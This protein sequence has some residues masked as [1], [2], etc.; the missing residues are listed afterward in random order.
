[1]QRNP[2]TT[3]AAIMALAIILT[4]S[5]GVI[6]IFR[7]RSLSDT[8]SVTGSAEQTVMSDVAKWSLQLTQSA[9]LYNL[10]TANTAISADLGTLRAFLSERGIEPDWITIQPVS[11]NTNYDYNKGGTPSGYMLMQTVVV[12]GNDIEK[13]KS[14]AENVN[15]LL[16]KGALVSTMSLEYFY[17]GLQSIKQ[18]ILAQATIDARERARKMVEAAGSQLGS[19]R[20]ASMGVLQVTAV[21][22]VE[23]SDY[24][25]YDTSAL[26]KKVTAVVRASFGI[27]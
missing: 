9:D 18:D 15:S 26:E 19:L 13:I 25:M 12:E 16:N 4:G 27:R 7:M 2:I 8:I 24:G 20:A 23:V 22:S 3:A 5:I 6:G 1:M 14:A 11:M 17:S 10:E 21:N